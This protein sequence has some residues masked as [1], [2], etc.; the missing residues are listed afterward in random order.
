[1]R[2]LALAAAGLIAATNALAQAFSS[3]VPY[4]PTP[5]ST[6]D[7][8]LEL[9]TVGPDDFVMDLGSGDGRIVITAAKKFGA[10]G[11]G[12]EIEPGL[13]SLSRYQAG[14]AGVADRTKFVT[15]NLFTTDLRPV[16]VLT[17]YL[18]REL[19]LQL[20][21]RILE[22]L[23]P[24]A[25]V[26]TH[27]WDMGEWEPDVAETIPAPD[28]AVGIVRESKIFLWYVP[29]RLDG[30]WRLETPFTARGG[31]TLSLAQRFQRFDGALD[32]AGTRYPVTEGRARG[33]AVRFRIADGAFAGDYAGTAAQN[34]ITG[35]IF[36]YGASAGAWK[37]VRR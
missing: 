6:V 33:A 20:R 23:R 21:P 7:R 17:L 30:T 36:R 2:A 32:H 5:Q 25:R 22:Q 34:E 18:F 4:F 27:D 13:V 14:R 31:A 15:E 12:I 16:T 24:G 29:A 3:N 28:K 37:A 26:V 10:R 8:M 19:N 1:M 35:E 11:M 9:A